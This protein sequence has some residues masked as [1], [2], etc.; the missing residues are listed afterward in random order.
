MSSAAGLAKA[1]SLRCGVDAALRAAAELG[2]L[3]G[4]AKEHLSD[5]E[6]PA[7]AAD[8]APLV[9]GPPQRA[10]RAARR[11]EGLSQLLPLAKLPTL[12]QTTATNRNFRGIK[13]CSAAK[14][15]G[16]GDG[17]D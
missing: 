1:R 13:Q 14:S 7:V 6:G 5:G 2:L 12:G 11:P 8:P 17:E 15:E 4:V 3:S 16:T 9:P 10:R